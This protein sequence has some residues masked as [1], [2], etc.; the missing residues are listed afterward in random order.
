MYYS[1]AIFLVFLIPLGVPAYFWY[2]LY[3]HRD[4]IRGRPETMDAVFPSKKWTKANPGKVHP[5]AG[6]PDIHNR[7]PGNP[8]YIAVASLRLLFRFYK[9]NCHYFEVYFLTEKLILT[10]VVGLA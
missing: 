3:F 7:I 8:Q 10:G 9:P 1:F 6:E 4:S 2:K 5:Q